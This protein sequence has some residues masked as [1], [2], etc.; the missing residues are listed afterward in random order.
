MTALYAVYGIGGLGR[1]V[2]PLV[3]AQLGKLPAADDHTLVF[4]DDAA[5]AGQKVNGHD[6]VTYVEFLRMSAESRQ[7]AIAIAINSGAIRRRLAERCGADGISAFPVV[8]ESAMFLDAVEIGEGAIVGPHAL[9]T[10]NT[11]IGRHFCGNYH[12]YVAHD[13][14]V[15]DFVTLAPGAR[16]NGNTVLEDGAYVGSGAV[17]RQGSPGNPVVIGRNAVVGMGAVVTRSVAPGAI[18]IG[19]PA[20]PMGA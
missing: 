3:R 16:V 6:A 9:I 5:A 10:S 19:N 17:I 13:C 20:R 8:A 15:G 14:V 18:V 2:M 7:A 4:V 1:E 12:S 11:S